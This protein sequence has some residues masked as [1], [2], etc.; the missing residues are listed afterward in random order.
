MSRVGH[1]AHIG[2]NKKAYRVLV[3]ITERGRPPG[4]LR[5]IWKG[6]IKTDSTGIGWD[7]VN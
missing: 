1:V 7:D 2:G 3:V 4:R 6:N 5:H